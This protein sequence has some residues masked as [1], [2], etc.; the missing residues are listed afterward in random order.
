MVKIFIDAGHGGTDTGAV[1]NGLQEKALTLTIAKKIEAILK[2]YENVSVR[3]SR[4]SDT[5]LSLTQ[6]TNAANAWGADFFL[7]VHIN[8][9]GGSGYE[10]YRYNTLS[11]TSNTG[12]IQA[13]IHTAV[14]NELKVFGVFDRGAKS[15]NFHVLRESNMNAVLTENLFVD[16]KADADLIKRNDVLDAI[17]RGHVTGIAKA[18]NLKVKTT[19]P[20]QKPATT[21]TASS[22]PSIMYDAHIQGI[23]WQG[24]KRDG[25]TAGTTG[26][27]KRLEALTVRLKN[28]NAELEM[29][30]HVQ[31]KGWTTLRGNGEVI[32]TIGLGLRMEAIRLKVTGLNVQYRVH[33]EYDGWTEWKRNGEE[34]G[35]TGQSKRIEAIEIKFV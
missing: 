19:Q 15:A 26:E 24:W 30:G 32:G 31:G 10:D 27:S 29:Q 33:V 2:S 13:A 18:F 28:P 8:A 7:S 23:G 25:Q 17:A 34:A 14:M 35:T 11:A 1:G 9:G 20:T 3:M 21:T 12:K 6:R 4:T 22:A 16:T 5:T